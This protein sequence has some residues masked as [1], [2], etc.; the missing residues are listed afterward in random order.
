MAEFI[1]P[2]SP[3]DINSINNGNE[4]VNGDGIQ[5]DAINNIVLAAFYAQEKAHEASEKLEDVNQFVDDAVQEAIGDITQQIINQVYPVGSYFITEST[6]EPASIFGGQWINLVD[7][8]LFSVDTD[9]YSGIED[10]SQDAVVVEHSHSLSLDTAGFSTIKSNSG[11]GGGNAPYI[12]YTMDN[13]KYSSGY[14]TTTEG[15]SGID[16]NMPPYRTVYMWRRIA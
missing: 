3:I 10:G 12:S 1:I 8:F 16:A 13:T 2:D 14:V 15:S 7:R 4:Y 11:Q 6:I 5:A 9:F